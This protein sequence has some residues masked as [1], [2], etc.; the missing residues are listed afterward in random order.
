MITNC[1]V[2]PSL[3]T[4]IFAIATNYEGLTKMLMSTNYDRLLSLQTR[5]IDSR[6]NHEGLIFL[7]TFMITNP[8]EVSY[9]LAYQQLPQIARG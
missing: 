1:E 6:Q 7:Q 2:L 9:K 3:Q 5:Y 4:D 8:E